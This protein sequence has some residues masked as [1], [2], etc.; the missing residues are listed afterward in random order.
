MLQEENFLF[1]WN[2]KICSNFLNFKAL[3]KNFSESF[4]KQLILGTKEKINKRTKNYI[5]TCNIYIYIKF[6]NLAFN[7]FDIDIHF[8][9]IYHRIGI[10]S[11]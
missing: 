1:K 9:Y 10:L 11:Q 8:V 2:Q 3:S 4:K 6:N 5:H 7:L